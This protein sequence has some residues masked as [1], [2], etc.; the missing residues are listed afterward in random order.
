M[1]TDTLRALLL[2]W[3]GY[4]TTVFEFIG[5]EHTAKNVMIAAIKR[6]RVSGP[7]IGSDAESDSTRNLMRAK[8]VLASIEAGERAKKV[9]KKKKFQSVSVNAFGDVDVDSY[10]ENATTESRAGAEAEDSENQ[11]KLDDIADMI[12]N[13]ERVAIMEEEEES[14]AI[15]RRIIN[16]M[17]TFGVKN[18]KLYD[19]IFENEAEEMRRN[20]NKA[21]MAEEGSVDVNKEPSGEFSSGAVGEEKVKKQLKLKKFRR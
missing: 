17:K 20:K 15:A 21:V 10:N 6:P 4:S 3:C 13:N 16:L 9:E 5:G 12:S 18:F 2:E 19:L 11:Q 7:I 14:A 8:E 1:V